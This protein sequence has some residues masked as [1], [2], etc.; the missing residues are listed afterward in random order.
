MVFRSLR[1]PQV[2]RV[3]VEIQKVDAVPGV[4]M[5]SML[6]PCGRAEPGTNSHS[7]IEPAHG[8]TRAVLVGW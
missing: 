6:L 3:F 1:P 5:T 4:V 8:D 7:A 2:E